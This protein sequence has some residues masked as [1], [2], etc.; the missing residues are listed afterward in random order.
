MRPM[1]ASQPNALQSVGG[2]A[3]GRGQEGVSVSVRVP[4]TKLPPP[5]PPSP[6]LVLWQ[7]G[8]QVP[9]DGL[10]VDWG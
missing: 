6:Q 2:W 5:S 1:G 8:I 10:E 4:T 9:E 7:C 3:V